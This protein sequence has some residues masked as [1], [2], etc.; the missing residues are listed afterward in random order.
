[1]QDQDQ[2]NDQDQANINY[3]Y[4]EMDITMC[5]IV[6]KIFDVLLLKLSQ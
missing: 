5:F 4:G 2:T 1:M 3:T 6:I